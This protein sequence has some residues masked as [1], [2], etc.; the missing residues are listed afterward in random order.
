V[1]LLRKI[2]LLYRSSDRMVLVMKHPKDNAFWAF[3][4]RELK[5]HLKRTVE[6]WWLVFRKK[7]NQ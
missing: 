4:R 7:E 2:E 5:I 1:S 6:A 3:M